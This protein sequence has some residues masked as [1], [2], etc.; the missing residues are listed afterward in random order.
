MAGLIEEIQRNALD[1]SVPVDALLRRV[2]LA[3]AKL[4]LPPLASWVDQ[5]LNG[6]SCSA[7]ELPEYRKLHGQ[8][9]A[10]NPYNGWIPVHCDDR[11]LADM[12]SMAPVSQ[13]CASLQDL[14]NHHEGGLLHFP[15]P[16][17][18][19]GELNKI[20]NFQTARMIIQINRG[21]L[22]GILDTVRNTVLDWAIEMEGK[23]VIGEGLSFNAE[24][25]AQAKE[26]MTT[27]HIGSIG[28]LAGNLGVGNS[29]GAINADQ[30]NN[31]VELFTSLGNAILQGI[32]DVSARQSLLAAVQR[33]EQSRNSR[34]L[35]ALAYGD[36]ISS[37]AAHMTVIAPFLPALGRLLS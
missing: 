34:E 35:F 32:G 23:G 16:A 8:P 7:A 6:Y 13:S 25:K 9:A 4:G 3:A 17:G 19:V 36:F 15:I 31:D 28:N 2:K 26:A 33:M 21:H 29:S 14:M 11:Q 24:E 12:I 20:M 27:I 1:S 5:E 18:L 30:A 37:A 22:V 10:W